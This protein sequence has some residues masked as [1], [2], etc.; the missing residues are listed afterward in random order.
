MNK[1]ERELFD[2]KFEN[3]HLIISQGFGEIKKDLQQ[4][5]EYNKNQNGNIEKVF[6]MAINNEKEIKEINSNILIKL[7]KEHPWGCIII[8]FLIILFTIGIKF[9]L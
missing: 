7:L 6:A 9:I 3:V 8:G 5:I 1:P 2:A 4:I